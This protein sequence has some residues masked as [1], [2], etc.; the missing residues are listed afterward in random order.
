MAYR[1]CDDCTF[2]DG[3]CILNHDYTFENEYHE[4]KCDDGNGD[5]FLEDGDGFDDD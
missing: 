5:I 1:T 2:N 4:N 3:W